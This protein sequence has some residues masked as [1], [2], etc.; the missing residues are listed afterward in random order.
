MVLYT[1]GAVLQFPDAPDVHGR[2]AIR[3]T[4]AGVFAATPIQSLEISEDTLEVFGDVAYEWGSFDEVYGAS[5]QPPVR[6][7]GRYLMR[8]ER[9]VD[10][11]WRV[12]RFA[13]NTISRTTG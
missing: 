12:S 2:D 8:W 9:G 4:L 10:G 7:V 13:G 5:G 6:D 3:E 11:Q 1:E